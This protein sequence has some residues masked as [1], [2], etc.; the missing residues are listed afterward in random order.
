MLVIRPIHSDWVRERFKRATER[1]EDAQSSLV[2]GC[3][4][5]GM[6]GPCEADL[7]GKDDAPEGN[8]S[9]RAHARRVTRPCPPHMPTRASQCV[10][11]GVWSKSAPICK[12]VQFELYLLVCRVDDA[13]C[14]ARLHI[15][16]KIG[17]WQQYQWQQQHLRGPL[18]RTEVRPWPTA[19]QG[20]VG[21][22]ENSIILWRS[23]TQIH[24]QT[25]TDR[26]LRLL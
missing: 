6:I 4:S 19:V 14:R 15:I 24:I 25:P 3:N 17:D 16:R 21:K 5:S 22:P 20:V 7:F 8:D 9:Q 26:E 1:R 11:A 10:L 12:R 13:G 23:R 18:C 2:A